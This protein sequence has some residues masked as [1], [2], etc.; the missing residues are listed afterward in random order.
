MMLLL[1]QVV[2]VVNDDD[3]DIVGIII[4]CGAANGG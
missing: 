3:Y 2:L 1:V 4:N